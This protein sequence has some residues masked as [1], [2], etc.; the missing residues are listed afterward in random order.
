MAANNEEAA[1]IRDAGLKMWCDKHLVS[2]TYMSWEPPIPGNGILAYRDGS[3]CSASHVI[4]CVYKQA[5]CTY[6]AHVE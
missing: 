2:G 5:D 4:A 1:A 6:V 3:A